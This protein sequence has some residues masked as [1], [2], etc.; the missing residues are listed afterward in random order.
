MGNV[1]KMK[2]R[3]GKLERKVQ[4]WLPQVWERNHAIRTFNGRVRVLDFFKGTVQEFMY[5]HFILR[6]TEFGRYLMSHGFQPTSIPSGFS[7]LISTARTLWGTAPCPCA[8]AP[9]TSST[10]VPARCSAGSSIC[11]VHALQMLHQ[12]LPP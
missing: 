12:Q 4:R 5:S 2:V 1:E 8:S 9:L 3:G 6:I 11:P 7:P 10:R